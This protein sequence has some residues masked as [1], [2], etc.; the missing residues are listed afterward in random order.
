M[1]QGPR[2]VR[3]MEKSRGQ[4]SRATVPLSVLTVTLSSTFCSLTVSVLHGL[5]PTSSDIHSVLLCSV[6]YTVLHFLS[7]VHSVNS[8]PSPHSVQ[9]ILSSIFFLAVS[10]SIF[11]P[12]YSVIQ[13]LTV[14]SCHLDSF[15]H[16]SILRFLSSISYPI[17]IHV[18][19]PVHYGA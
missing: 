2:Y 5:C 12:S 18:F 4:K 15:L 9:H 19:S 11:C 17:H 7:S 10:A 8:I 13:I 16:F 1:N 6:L 3:L 14:S